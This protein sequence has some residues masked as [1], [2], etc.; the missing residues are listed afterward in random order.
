MAPPDRFDEAQLRRRARE[1]QRA[2]RAGEPEAMA[3]VTAQG[4]DP[5]TIGLRRAQ[6][7]LAREEG[8]PSWPAL[9][10]AAAGTGS[11]EPDPRR[12]PHWP[13][14]AR[15]PLVA[16]VAARAAAVADQVGRWH[17]AGEQLVLVAT[18]PDWSRHVPLAGLDRARLAEHATR[19][20]NQ[21]APAGADATLGTSPMF[22]EYLGLAAGLAVGQGWT[23]LTGAH[24]I[25][26]ALYAGHRTSWWVHAVA[27]DPDA[28]VEQLPATE[29]P[30]VFP[31][32]LEPGR[33]PQGDLVYYPSGAEGVTLELSRRHPPGK[34]TRWGL[35]AS[36]WKP[37]FHYIFGDDEIPV[38][39]IVRSVL[40]DPAAAFAVPWREALRRE[41]E[42]RAVVD[43]RPLPVDATPFRPRGEPT[44]ADAASPLPAEG[45]AEAPPE[46]GS[47][48]AH[49][50]EG[51]AL[52]A[53][54][55]VGAPEA[56]DRVLAHHPIYTGRDPRRL[57]LT[58]LHLTDAYATV[59]AEAGHG[60]WMELVAAAD[61]AASGRPRPRWQGRA[62]SALQQA[63]RV[64]A[65]RRDPDLR[66]AHVVLALLQGPSGGPAASAL[67]RLGVTAD[68]VT[69]RLGPGG[70]PDVRLG[71]GSNPMWH[72]LVGWADGLALGRG[73]ER[74]EAADVL[75]AL[76]YG[77]SPGT[78]AIEAGAEA[79]DVHEALSALGHTVPGVRP[80][81]LWSS[82]PTSSSAG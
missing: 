33:P 55:E 42:A 78:L 52:L 15:P 73:V 22:E 50:A 27:L 31:V 46:P 20:Y 36:T 17:M 19:L 70:P 39:E 9:V 51:R 30:P 79:D 66:P 1:L 37:G 26:A 41:S 11:E 71:I 25:S 49:R 81:E 56:A 10:A 16:L 74:V 60:S 82:A 34:G 13:V 47:L 35:N 62:A 23:E 3:R 14:P 21:T 54:I 69:A 48:A 45:R 63:M 75:L 43:G 40:A 12:R 4:L 58:A 32:H 72:H 2:A 53:A 67:A 7:V 65:E 57:D 5:G 68:S 18:D 61:T 24:L 59:A 44:T 77:L 6:H 76:A 80:S 28:A 29:R 64:A 8:H 38:L